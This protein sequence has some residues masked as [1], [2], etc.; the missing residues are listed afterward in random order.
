MSDLGRSEKAAGAGAVVAAA[1]A[2][3]C[4]ILPLGLGAVGTGWFFFCLAVADSPR[5]SLTNS[6]TVRSRSSWE[7]YAAIS[8]SR[9]VVVYQCAEVGF[10]GPHFFQVGFVASTLACFPYQLVVRLRCG[11]NHV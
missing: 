9:C 4:C 7:I 10:D 11:F 6:R 3:M 8:R 5:N 2:S 1:L